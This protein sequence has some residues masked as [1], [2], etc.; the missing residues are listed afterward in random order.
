[1]N[2]ITIRHNA[3]DAIKWCSKEFGSNFEVLVNF[4]GNFYTFSFPKQKQAILFA[5][6]W[7]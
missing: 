1:M 4:P 5:L 2:S 3:Y 7:S 6:K